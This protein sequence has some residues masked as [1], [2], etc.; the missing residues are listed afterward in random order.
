[1]NDKKKAALVKQ[2]FSEEEIVAM[3][4][5]LFVKKEQDKV[6]EWQSSLEHMSLSE[7]KKECLQKAALLRAKS[8]FCDR[9]EQREYNRIARNLG[10][11]VRG[12]GS[13]TW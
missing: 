1:M 3:Q 7:V 4:T 5:A 6:E 10:Y 2:G 11:V 13:V 12:P 9:Y 8:A